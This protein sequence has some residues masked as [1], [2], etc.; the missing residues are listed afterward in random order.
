MAVNGPTVVT[1]SD[2]LGAYI[3]DR[4]APQRAKAAEEPDA[5]IFVGY[6]S[7]AINAYFTC[8]E[9]GRP[10]VRPTTGV[11][12]EVSAAL[13]TMA[14]IATN[15]SR[16]VDEIMTANDD[17]WGR[18]RSFAR[19]H[20]QGRFQ[21]SDRAYLSIGPTSLYCTE[22]SIDLGVPFNR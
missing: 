20:R 15:W 18:W 7:D 1:E 13:R 12:T 6:A 21:L 5:R 3:D 22:Q 10:T 2:A 19:R 9:L 17:A 11:P 8:M 16:A 4:L 14:P